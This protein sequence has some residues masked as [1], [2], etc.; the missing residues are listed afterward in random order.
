MVH[1]RLGTR[2]LA[3]NEIRFETA[4]KKKNGSGPPPGANST[5]WAG[6][7]FQHLLSYKSRHTHVLYSGIKVTMY[8]LWEMRTVL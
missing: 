5:T 2:S 7:R 1:G 4:L 8:H 6:F 3:F